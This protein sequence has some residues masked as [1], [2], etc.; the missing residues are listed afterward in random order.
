MGELRSRS[1]ASSQETVAL[2]DRLS[3]LQSEYQVALRQHQ[4]SAQAKVEELS[5][6]LDRLDAQ[7]EKA[8]HDLEETLAV[9]AS[10]NKE[11]QAALKNPASPRAAGGTAASSSGDYSRLQAEL[12][13]CVLSLLSFSLRARS[14]SY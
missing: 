2:H 9:N 4:D 13:Q 8:N 3:T 1:E 5:G 7:L 10:L 12:E 6:E 14:S 11:L